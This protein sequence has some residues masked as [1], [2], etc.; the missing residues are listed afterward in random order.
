MSGGAPSRG[1]AVGVIIARLYRPLKKH[2]DTPMREV[3]KVGL[4][5]L[6]WLM[7]SSLTATAQTTNLLKDPSFEANTGVNVVADGRGQPLDGT[8]YNVPADWGGWVGTSPRTED[9]MNRIPD[10]YPHTGLFKIDGSRSWSVSRGFA[11]FT[12]AMYQRVAVAKGTNVRGSV[13]GFME[14]GKDASGNTIA[15]GQFRIGI[16]PNGGTD[17]LSG[18]IIWSAVVT[19]PNGW[20][21]AT[22][23]ATAAGDAVTLFLYATQSQPA[24]PNAM[25]WDNA[26][27]EVG[28]TGASV[29]PSGT[30][31]APVVPTPAFAPF[32][33]PQGTQ[34]DGSVVHIVGSGDTIDAI[35]VAYQTTRAAI[36]E[37]N[38]DLRPAF[39]FPGQEIIVRPPSTATPTGGGASG[40][41]TSVPSVASGTPATTS[42]TSAVTITGTRTAVIIAAATTETDTETE[43]PAS[44]TETPISDVSVTVSPTAE[45][46]ASPTEG[47]P[48]PTA[49]PTDA[50][51]TNT[52][53]PTLTATDLPPAPVTQVADVAAPEV[54][55]LCMWVFE[56]VNQNRIQEEGERLLPSGKVEVLQGEAL[57][58]EYNTDGVSEP[59]CFTDIAPGDYIARAV[60]PDG[61]GLTTSTSLNLRVQDG[62][63]TNV[64]FGAAQGV[65]AAQ[66]PIVDAQADAQADSA[67]I[68]DTQ[69]VSQTDSLL[70]IAGLVLFG[71]A[72]LVI[73]GGIG[74]A[75][76]VRGR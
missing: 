14:R 28:G 57:L 47:T 34:P 53:E 2:G 15:G 48:E 23:D 38:P 40:A 44:V 41:N 67:P 7:V 75:L 1:V 9:W 19:S 13:R 71:L 43:T 20:V 42:P 64:R 16:D 10:G 36:L 65:E 70:Q 27:L 74:V 68:Q 54:T 6:M 39:I 58:R 24:N 46:S 29:T 25:Y 17:P 4:T 22:V 18:A 35:A 30:A 73:L 49:T 51:P 8:V 31:G 5:L 33:A 3:L 52:P 66:P 50:P 63:R 61:F 60:A 21:Q 37:L 11:T 56:D 62:V 69:A 72:G 55:S 32:V 26:T 76:Y 59:F 45:A 12:A